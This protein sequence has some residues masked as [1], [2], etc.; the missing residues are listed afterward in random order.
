M[1]LVR[2]G[3]ET[4]TWGWY[5]VFTQ[6]WYENEMEPSWNE[7]ELWLVQNE[8]GMLLYV[9]TISWQ[10]RSM[11]LSCIRVP[12][13]WCF[14]SISRIQWYQLNTKQSVINSFWRKFHSIIIK[15]FRILRVGGGG[16]GGGT[17]PYK[18]IRDVPFFR[19]S[20]FNLIPEPDMK[21]DKK[22]LNRLWH[23][24]SRTIGYCFP[25]CFLEIL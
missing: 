12:K 4:K 1:L 6:F 21:I 17:L 22:F 20:F 11:S 15:S 7:M 19:V 24:C 10:Y 25:Y 16:G 14:H 8:T 2:L 5:L 3:N 13:P 9:V 18:P 23:I